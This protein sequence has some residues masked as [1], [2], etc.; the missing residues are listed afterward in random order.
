M[1]MKKII[2]S[3]T[4]F[5][6]ILGCGQSSVTTLPYDQAPDSAV[7]A[8]V[9]NSTY[10]KAELERDVR[11]MSKLLK[12]AGYGADETTI[13]DDPVAYRQIVLKNFVMREVVVHE[14]E[15][16][17]IT[18]SAQEINDYQ[19]RFAANFTQH[20]PLS[21]K[22]LLSA[23]GNE[24]T[25]FRANLHKDALA[26]KFQTIVRQQLAARIAPVSKDDA[27]ASREAAL[28]HNSRLAGEN[29]LIG[30]LATNA[31]KSIKAGNDFDVVGRKLS[32]MR[33]EISFDANRPDNSAA[34]AK[35]ANGAVP[36]PS[37]IP[38]GLAL[39]K[40]R[41]KRHLSYIQFTF[42]SPREVLSVKDQQTALKDKAVGA[43]YQELLNKLKSQADISS[44]EL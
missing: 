8:R 17:G 36:P 19:E 43:A 44:L 28:R 24:A 23:L 2:P 4:I 14:A 15:H 32:E 21:F 5:T 20:M 12:S 30:K 34:E 3:V 40:A 18:L 39:A 26:E 7:I 13:A 27:V 16:R 10:T 1:T 37:A 35:F 29:R 38:G 25:V 6:I 9:D 33:K 11:I 41:D 22:S 42:Q 31:W